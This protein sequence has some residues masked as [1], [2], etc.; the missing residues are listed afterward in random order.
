MNHHLSLRD[1]V[2]ETLDNAVSNGFAPEIYNHSDG[3]VSYALNE[4][5]ADLDG[6]SVEEL[7]PHVEAWR[8]DNR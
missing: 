7:L 8:K 4:F 2:F 5:N 6:F 3:Q 1:Q